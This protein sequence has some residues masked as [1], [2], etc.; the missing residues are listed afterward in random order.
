MLQSDRAD[1]ECVI[2]TF[3]KML[4][5][6]LNVLDYNFIRDVLTSGFFFGQM[7]HGMSGIVSDPSNS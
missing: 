3:N 7:R 1:R 5:N 6:D 4:T 2:G